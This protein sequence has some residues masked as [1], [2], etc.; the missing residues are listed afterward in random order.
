MADDSRQLP[1][2]HSEI[3]P[4][5]T[6]FEAFFMEQQ[7]KAGLNGGGLIVPE[8]SLLVSYLTWLKPELEGTPEEREAL[9]ARIFQYR[10]TSG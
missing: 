10:P 8:K 5:I 2:K 3:E 4:H 6:A 9:R 1:S 7:K